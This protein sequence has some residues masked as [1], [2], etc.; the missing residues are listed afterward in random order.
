M[1][2]PLAA[3]THINVRLTIIALLLKWPQVVLHLK[4][5]LSL[6]TRGFRIRA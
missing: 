3:I 6:A 1:R 2:Q 5:Q 4:K